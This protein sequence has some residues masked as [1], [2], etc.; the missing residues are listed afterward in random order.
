[1]WCV[2][3][4][5][6]VYVYVAADSHIDSILTACLPELVC[7]LVSPHHRYCMYTIHISTRNILIPPYVSF[8][9]LLLLREFDHMSSFIILYTPLERVELLHSC[10]TVAPTMSPHPSCCIPDTSHTLSQNGTSK[11]RH[12]PHAGRLK[13]DLTDRH[14]KL[15]HL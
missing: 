15:K 4:V 8:H 6:H 10:H 9:V 1:M 11:G 3:L 2:A 7:V 12:L 5:V 13:I 14:V